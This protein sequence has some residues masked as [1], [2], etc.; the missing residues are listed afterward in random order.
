MLSHN[1]T[2]VAFGVGRSQHFTTSREW[3]VEQ[4]NPTMNQDVEYIGTT[5]LLPASDDPAVS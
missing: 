3:V 5:T 4:I 2:G 1:E